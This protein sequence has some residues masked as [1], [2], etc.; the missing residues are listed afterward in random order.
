MPNL[1]QGLANLSQG[2]TA[3]GQHAG[4][5]EMAQALAAREE[6]LE[7]LR[8]SNQMNIEMSKENA[9]G[10]RES[11][12]DQ[13]YI[14]VQKLRDEQQDKQQIAITDRTIKGQENTAR[15]AAAG[16]AAMGDRQIEALRQ[17]QAIE[18]QRERGQVWQQYQNDIKAHEELEAKLRNEYVQA[19]KGRMDLALLPPDQ[20]ASAIAADPAISGIQA[21]L[22]ALSQR[23][24]QI[25]ASYTLRLASL[26]DPLISSKGLTTAQLNQVAP[27]P[28]PSGAL[29]TNSSATSPSLMGGAPGGGADP[30]STGP[31]ISFGPGMNTGPSLDP[32]AA[33]AAPAPSLIPSTAAPAA[34]A[35]TGSNSPMLIPPPA[36]SRVGT[37]P[38]LDGQY[39]GQQPAPGQ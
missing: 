8:A 6:N 38:G 17:Q 5:E 3:V 31:K 30:F 2:L 28:A 12:R 24:R 15:I 36:V 16:Y 29:N 9:A 4:T 32:I 7:R 14:D 34:P 21:Q 27:A 11:A 39:P 35:P 19:T 18:Q 33:G 37:A 25:N 13:R 22:D 10:Q 26:N 20:R 23:R 1:T